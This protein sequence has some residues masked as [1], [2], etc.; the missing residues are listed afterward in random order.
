MAK[1]NKPSV[2]EDSVVSATKDKK[3][4]AEEDSAV[5]GKKLFVE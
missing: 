1:G 5:K 3:P 4:L 2:E